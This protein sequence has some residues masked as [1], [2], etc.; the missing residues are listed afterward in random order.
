M[1]GTQSGG[2]D[3]GFGA[4]GVVGGRFP[5]HTDSPNPSL[6]IGA[7]HRD[8]PGNDDNVRSPVETRRSARILE[9]LGSREAPG[10]GGLRLGEREIENAAAVAVHAKR[11]DKVSA[12][13][14]D[15]NGLALHLGAGMRRAGGDD[16]LG[17]F[18]VESR[19]LRNG[20][21][22]KSDQDESQ[23]T[24]GCQVAR[25]FR[26][27]NELSTNS[28]SPSPVSAFIASSRRSH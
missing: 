9:H 18:G 25:F 4:F 12:I 10:R 28:Y 13:I 5:R 11:R 24:H 8:S 19:L 15:G 21:R 1:G 20:S 14:D 6:A 3:A 23:P 2:L 17:G 16:R 26:A 22:W 27:R 7:E